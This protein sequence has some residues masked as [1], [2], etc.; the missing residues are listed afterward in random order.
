MHADLEELKQRIATGRYEV[1]PHAIAG[2]ILRRR[3]VGQTV[4]DVLVPA[5]VDGGAV[6]AE[7]PKPG[8][9]GDAA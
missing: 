8:P 5:E 1:D 2:A 7:Q 4:S 6:R 3:A 9:G